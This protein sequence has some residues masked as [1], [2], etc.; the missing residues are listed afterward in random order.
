M[1]RFNTRFS[2]PPVRIGLSNAS[3]QQR[4]MTE[5]AARTPHAAG[6]FVE[7]TGIVRPVPIRLRIDKYAGPNTN[8]AQKRI[9][10]MGRT[11]R[12]RGYKPI[13]GLE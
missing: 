1:G 8:Q 5:P 13:S 6:G 4:Q 9:L 2:P 3:V 12:K 11:R 7:R 10:V